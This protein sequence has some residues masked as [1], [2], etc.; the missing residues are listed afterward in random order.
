VFAA[1]RLTTGFDDQLDV[2]RNVAPDVL[3]HDPMELAAP[4]IAALLGR[5]HLCIGYLLPLRPALQA[6]AAEGVGDR[7]RRHGLDVPADAGIHGDL[8]LDP[9]PPSLADPAVPAP[10]ARHPMR[11]SWAAGDRDGL[12]E[13]ISR[14]GQLRPLVYATIGTLFGRAGTEPLAVMIDGLRRLDV[15]VIATVGPDCDPLDLDP[16]DPGVVVERFVP[17]DLVLARCSLAVIHGGSGSVLG[18]LQHEIPMVVVPLG[19]DQFDNAAAVDRAG[20]GVV[21]TPDRLSVDT[22][23]DAAARSL[24]DDD[25]RTAAAR[26]AAELAAMPTAADLVPRI[27]QLAGAV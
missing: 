2:A 10:A 8:Y 15:D 13:R 18:A 14:L 21:V 20:A 16:G 25:Q 9:C 3:L 27:E 7:W 6:A 5:P 26:V 11:A 4:L 19:A 1:E 23:T 22:I 17:Q 24:V 12:P